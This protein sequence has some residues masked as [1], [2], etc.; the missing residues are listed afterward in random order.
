[1]GK[2]IHFMGMAEDGVVVSREVKGG[3]NCMMNC[4]P[5]CMPTGQAWFQI[6]PFPLAWEYFSSLYVLA[7]PFFLSFIF[8]FPP[9]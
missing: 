3:M 4:R 1:M 2:G 8:L 6:P 7:R 9:I 5:S